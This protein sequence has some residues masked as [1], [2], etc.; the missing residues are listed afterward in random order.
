MGQQT[1]FF[2]F[3][4]SFSFFFPP[5]TWRRRRRRRRRN[6]PSFSSSSSSFSFSTSSSSFSSSF[7]TPLTFQ[8][9]HGFC[10]CDLV[11]IKLYLRSD[12][13]EDR[14]HAPRGDKPARWYLSHSESL[15]RLKIWYYHWNTSNEAAASATQR[16]L[17]H[18]REL[19]VQISQYACVTTQ[20]GPC[21]VIL[22]CLLWAQ[23]P[24]DLM[25][26]WQVMADGCC[27]SLMAGDGRWLLILADGW[28]LMLLLLLCWVSGSF[29]RFC[30]MFQIF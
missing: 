29:V 12:L 21:D 9:D 2:F 4:F 30:F 5:P 1:D 16:P 3:F 20:P 8:M 26:W 15:A 13:A 28:W 17:F 6:T 10:V 22:P 18:S 11:V 25:D 14:T 23:W 24:D 7:Y 19:K 27:D